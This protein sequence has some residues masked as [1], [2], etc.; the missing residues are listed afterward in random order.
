MKEGY[1]IMKKYSDAS[2]TIIKKQ[3]NQKDFYII[4]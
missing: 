1:F 2:L 4:F 3:M